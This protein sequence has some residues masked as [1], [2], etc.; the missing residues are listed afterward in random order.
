[1]FDYAGFSS[2]ETGLLEG[3][4]YASSMLEGGY[5][6]NFATVLS[7]LRGARDNAEVFQN[8]KS[9]FLGNQTLNEFIGEVTTDSGFFGDANA[10]AALE[11]KPFVEYQIAAGKSRERVEADLK[12][13]FE[14]NYHPMQGVVIDPA[15]QEADRSRQ[16][17]SGR[18]GNK[19]PAVVGIMNDM[20]SEMGVGD[21]RFL[22][23][24]IGREGRG[25]RSRRRQGIEEEQA[26]AEITTEMRLMPLPFAG[27][28]SEDVRYMAVYVYDTGDVIPYVKESDE[29]PEFIYFSLDDLERRFRQSQ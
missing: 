23:D 27:G 10:N 6:A 24:T 28:A 29:G 12:R 25:S 21:A 8:Q 3:A 18:F 5:Q 16:A 1:M 2:E 7:Q 19:V 20:L 13:Y 4:L 9:R 26:P 15:F 22:L 11:M 17:L 14:Q